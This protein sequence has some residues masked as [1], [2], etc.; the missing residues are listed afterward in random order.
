MTVN[1]LPHRIVV[2][3]PFPLDDQDLREAD[4]LLHSI[5]NLVHGLKGVQGLDLR[6]LSRST[7]VREERTTEISGVPVTF[8]PDPTPVVDFMLGRRLLTGRLSNALKRLRPDLVHAHG[9]APY[10]LAALRSD[11]PH[12]ITLQSIFREQTQPPGVDPPLRYRVAYWRMRS[13]E[14]QYLP[15]IRNLLAVNE[16]IAAQ[17]RRVAPSVRIFPT[18]NTAAESFFSTGT[19]EAGPIVLSVSQISQRKGLHHLLAAFEQVA[20][21]VAGCQLRIVGAEVQDPSYAARL[22]EEHSELIAAGR[23]IFLGGLRHD[24]IRGELGRCRVFCLA[25]LYEASPLAVAEAMAAGKPVVVTRVGDLEELVGATGAGIVVDPGDVAGL[26]AGLSRL[27]SAPDA[28]RAAM[29]RLGREAARRRAHPDVAA[30]D[31]LA[32]YRQILAGSET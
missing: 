25:S 24:E 6:V 3:G 15:A 30:Q 8:V 5:V 29:G 10:I 12:V 27:L 16:T 31:A 2:C 22:R 4:G 32:A 23:V 18:T 19:T 9:E 7:K 14:R 1:P 21:V 28:E 11:R 20:P 17:V 13:W 26:A